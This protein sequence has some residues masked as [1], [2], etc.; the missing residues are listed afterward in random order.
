MN[1]TQ[2]QKAWNEGKM[3][4]RSQWSER[5][6]SWMIKRYS[7]AGGWKQYSNQTYSSQEECE[8]EVDRLV[9]GAD[10]IIKDI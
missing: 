8:K 4:I 6:K 3:I 10:F 2:K 5:Y 7:V 1:K 9:A